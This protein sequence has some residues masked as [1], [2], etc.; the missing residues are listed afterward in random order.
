MVGLEFRHQADDDAKKPMV[1]QFKS[2][3]S[4]ATDYRHDAPMS[5]VNDP[6]HWRQRAEDMRALAKSESDITAKSAMMQIAENYDRLA[7]RAQ[8]RADTPARP[9]DDGAAN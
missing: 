2:P 8:A 3:L 5:S 9:R 7:E 6:K 4:R 1:A